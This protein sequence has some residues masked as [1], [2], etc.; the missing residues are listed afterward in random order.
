VS[1]SIIL[2]LSSFSL[3]SALVK[4]SAISHLWNNDGDGLFWP[5][6]DVESDDICIDVLRSI[7]E[8]WVL[9]Q[10]Y[11]RGIVNHEWS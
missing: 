6:H 1:P 5:Q 11:C 7:M 8:L 9:G 2:N 10:L 3:P 4:M